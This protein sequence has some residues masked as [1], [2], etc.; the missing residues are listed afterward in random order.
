MKPKFLAMCGES[1]L[2]KDMKLRFAGLIEERCNVLEQ[3]N[4]TIG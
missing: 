2:P 3:G 1:L 4:P